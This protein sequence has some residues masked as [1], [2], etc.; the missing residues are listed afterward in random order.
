MRHDRLTLVDNQSTQNEGARMILL[1]PTWL[2]SKYSAH[3]SEIWGPSAVDDE[4]VEPND[5]LRFACLR[6][7]KG[8]IAARAERRQLCDV[9]ILFLDVVLPDISQTSLLAKLCESAE[10]LADTHRQGTILSARSS[11][12][13]GAA[14]DFAEYVDRI[15]NLPETKNLQLLVYWLGLRCAEMRSKLAKL[16]ADMAFHFEDVAQAG[17]SDEFR[18]QVPHAETLASKLREL[19]MLAELSQ[20]TSFVMTDAAAADTALKAAYEL[21]ETKRGTFDSAAGARLQRTS[22]WIG[23]AVAIAGFGA[24]GGLLFDGTAKPLNATLATLLTIAP[25]TVALVAFVSLYIWH[26]RISVREPPRESFEAVESLLNALCESTIF[27]VG[28]LLSDAK[29]PIA[30]RLANRGQRQQML[31]KIRRFE[32]VARGHCALIVEDLSQRHRAFD[33]DP[34]LGIDPT[35][36]IITT[37]VRGGE[38]LSSVARLNEK[39][40]LLEGEVPIYDC[41]FPDLAV[42]LWLKSYAL[43]NEPGSVTLVESTLRDVI[44]EHLKGDPLI[45]A[46]VLHDL[47]QILKVLLSLDDDVDPLAE[48]EDADDDLVDQIIAL[49]VKD[50][51]ERL[52]PLRLSTLCEKVVVMTLHA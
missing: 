18:R 36:S 8:E 27:P 52:A 5:A 44:C 9:E 41:P 34:T 32:G 40:R 43:D 1:A 42:F 7:T 11:F 20:C 45:V 50:L 24:L 28:A 13:A 47:R 3:A 22:T 23:I 29:P 2:T 19:P 15:A 48:I 17:L 26:A 21:L 46:G 12:F 33:A 14:G 37:R 4:V 25:A 10:Y 6:I 35:E 51:L 39:S 49:D 16:Q 31:D 38:R 30:M